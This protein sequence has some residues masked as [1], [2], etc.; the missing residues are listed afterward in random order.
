MQS[1]AGFSAV[2]HYWVICCLIILFALL[3]YILTNSNDNVNNKNNNTNAPRNGGF[4]TQICNKLN[5]NPNSQ[6]EVSQSKLKHLNP[7]VD[8][9]VGVGG[10]LADHNNL[11]K[12]RIAAERGCGTT[13]CM[14]ANSRHQVDHKSANSSEGNR[15]SRKEIDIALRRVNSKEHNSDNIYNGP[16]RSEIK[17]KTDINNAFKGTAVEQLLKRRSKRIIIFSGGGVTKLVVGVSFPIALADK[18]RSLGHYYNLQVQY[19]QI[20]TPLYWWNYFNSSAFAAR[21]QQRRQIN[22][23]REK[24]H[25]RLKQDVSRQFIYAAIEQIYERHG[26]PGESCLLQAICQVS[27]LPFHIPRIWQNNLGHLWHA[28]LNAIL[29]PTVPNVAMKYLHASQA[30]RFGV[31]CEQAFRECPQRVNEWLRHVAHLE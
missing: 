19:P 24:L 5:E 9:I 6:Q 31:D 2:R 3:L 1:F 20:T 8:G 13:N 25:Q 26:I 23:P 27:Q 17:S 11:P 7:S 10:S 4:R 12:S 21:H 18:Q 15:D 14:P 28:L 29:I 22:D 16:N 30:G